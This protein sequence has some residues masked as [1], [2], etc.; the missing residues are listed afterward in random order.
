MLFHSLLPKWLFQYLP[1][2]IALALV[3][4][5]TG[6]VPKA[7]GAP[8]PVTSKTFVVH[9]SWGGPPPGGDWNLTPSATLKL[10][11]NGKVDVEDLGVVYSDVGTW[12]T[13][14]GGRTMTIRLDGGA[15]YTGTRQTDGSYTG[16]MT[17]PNVGEPGVWRGTYVP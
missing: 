15:V 11:S 4:A 9:Y 12:S 8:R 1:A 6:L 13:A 2:M 5:F 10:Y 3:L 7:Q 16:T 17:S 14:R